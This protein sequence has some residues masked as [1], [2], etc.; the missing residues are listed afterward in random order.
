MHNA[1]LF[2]AN[3]ADGEVNSSGRRSFQPRLRNAGPS[4]MV[5]GR[6]PSKLIHISVNPHLKGRF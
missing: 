5:G 1:R 6:R 2:T 4:P 3:E